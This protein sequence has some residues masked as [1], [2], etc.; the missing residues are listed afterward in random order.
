[1]WLTEFRGTNRQFARGYISISSDTGQCKAKLLQCICAT[2]QW[3]Q[4]AKPVVIQADCSAAKEDQRIRMFLGSFLA[5]RGKIRCRL[6]VVPNTL[7]P[8]RWFSSASQSRCLRYSPKMRSK[9]MLPRT[10]SSSSNRPGRWSFTMT[11]PTLRNNTSGPGFRPMPEYDSTGLLPFSY[12]SSTGNVEV[13]D[14][15]LP[16]R[17]DQ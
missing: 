4:I 3:L 12:L 17:M 11:A 13:E 15:R 1:M 8:A 10:L 14:V 16:N 5:C 2:V 6:C 7:T 9:Q